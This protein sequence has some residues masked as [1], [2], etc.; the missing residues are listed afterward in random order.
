MKMNFATA[1]AI[2][3]SAMSAAAFAEPT[4]YT[5]V[6]RGLSP[7]VPRLFMGPKN[8]YRAGGLACVSPLLDED[9]MKKYVLPSFSV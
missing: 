4:V 9:L 6:S 8:Y 1:A 5:T 7:P 3:A 2:A